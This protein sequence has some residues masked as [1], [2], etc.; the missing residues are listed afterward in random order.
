MDLGIHRYSDPR[1]YR[2]E[3]P[4]SWEIQTQV[5]RSEIQNVYTL[6]SGIKQENVCVCVVFVCVSVCLS[7]CCLSVLCVCLCVQKEEGR[8]KTGVGQC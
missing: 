3:C 7:V 8:G 1:H 4:Y 5:L 2:R 6:F